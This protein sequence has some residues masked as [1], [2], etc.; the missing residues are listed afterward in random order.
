[1]DGECKCLG[2]RHTEGRG[3]F[4]QGDDDGLIRLRFDIVLDFNRNGSEG[5]IRPEN[6]GAIGHRMV[7]PRGCGA[8]HGIGG[9]EGC[10]L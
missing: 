9:G 3:S 4:R 5:L 10:G 8:P 2:I 6:R 7:E 1:M